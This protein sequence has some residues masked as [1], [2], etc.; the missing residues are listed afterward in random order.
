MAA[1]AA[2]LLLAGCATGAGADGRRRPGS[3]AAP[4]I[5]KGAKPFYISDAYTRNNIPA[6]P[7]GAH[8]EICPGPANQDPSYAANTGVSVYVFAGSLA[9]LPVTEA[10]SDGVAGDMQLGFYRVDTDPVEWTGIVLGF[11]PPYGTAGNGQL[12]HATTSFGRLGEGQRYFGPNAPITVAGTTPDG[13]PEARY[14]IG[15]RILVHY[16][17]YPRTFDLQ[18]QYH[19]HGVSAAP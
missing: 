11:T 12:I 10:T 16:G 4:G 6:N 17:S 7:R 19:I 9:L 1:V 5:P 3:F 14:Q 15:P 8:L 18:I 13:P 2:A